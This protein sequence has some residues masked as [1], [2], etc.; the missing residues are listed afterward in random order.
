VNVPLQGLNSQMG[1]TRLSELPESIVASAQAAQEELVAIA[2]NAV[3]VKQGESEN[4][5]YT[6]KQVSSYIAE[7]RKMETIVKSMIKAMQKLKR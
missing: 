5:I 7:A 2:E 1:H 6:S 3:A 4:L